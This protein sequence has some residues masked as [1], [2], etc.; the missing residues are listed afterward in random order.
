[1]KYNVLS[2]QLCCRS[3]VHRL[4][5]RVDRTERGHR[6]G[7]SGVGGMWS[8]D[9]FTEHDKLVSYPIHHQPQQ[10]VVGGQREGAGGQGGEE[11]F[12]RNKEQ[13]EISMDTM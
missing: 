6:P 8:H 12:E 4:G 7:R 11:E 10:Q 2:V 5:D 9:K 1:M 3:V 13:T